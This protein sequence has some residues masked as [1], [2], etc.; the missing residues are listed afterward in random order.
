MRSTLAPRVHA[1]PADAVQAYFD[2]RDRG[3]GTVIRTAFH[4]DAA[5][6]SVADDGSPRVLEQAEWWVRLEKGVTP[7]AE[8]RQSLLDREGGMALVEAT[9][10][11]STHEFRDLLI[12]AD[13]PEGWRIVGKVFTRIAA[14]E[15]LRPATPEDD[16]AIRQVVQVKIDAHVGYDPA[17]L[18]ASHLP[19]CRYF[20]VHVEGVDFLESSLS[21]GAARY[22]GMRERGE[23]G[24]D[25]KWRVLEVIPRADIAAVKLDAIYKGIRYIDYLL[26]LRTTDGWR[27]AAA[28][29][30]DPTQ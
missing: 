11:W 7:A 25:T 22:A 28:V 2:G 1:G 29:W 17:L 19:T 4:P 15:T 9:S 10:R 26:L 30:G 13:T 21:Q 20:R 12:L 14:G 6:Q 24:R 8:N 16:Q 27:I 5:L 3:S 18:V 23:H